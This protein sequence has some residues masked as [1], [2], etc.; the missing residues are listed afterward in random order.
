[1]KVTAHAAR[2]EGWWAFDVPEIDGLVTQARHLD[3]TP[4]WCEMLP[5]FST[6]SP[7]NPLR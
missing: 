5:N 3:Q 6:D 1:M 2:S 4:A 7:Q